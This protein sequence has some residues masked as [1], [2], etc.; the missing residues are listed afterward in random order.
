[1]SMFYRKSLNTV[2]SIVALVLYAA[3]SPLWR[4][5]SSPQAGM[6]WLLRIRT[7][8]TLLWILVCGFCGYGIY[9]LTQP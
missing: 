2:L 9:T 7:F 4:N 6:V 3:T 8:F 5:S 1:M